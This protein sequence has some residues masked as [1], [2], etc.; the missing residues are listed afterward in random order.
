MLLEAV[1]P[2]I[3]ALNDQ[4]QIDCGA[5]D[6]IL[7]RKQIPVGHIE[8][9]DI[10]D[11]LDRTEKGEQ[12]AKYKAPLENLILTDYL[13]FRFYLRGEKVDTVRIAEISGGRIVALPESFERLKTLL[14]DFAAFQGQTIRSAKKLA[15]MMA[16]KARLMREVFFNAVTG[17]EQS[18]LKDQLKA[19]QTILV[20]DMDARQFADV[21]AQTIAYGLFT[22]RLHDESRDDFSRGEALTLIPKSNPFLRQLFEYVAG[23]QLDE[24]VIWIVDELCKVFRAADLDAILKDFGTATGQKDPILHFYETFLAE[25]DPKL[26]KSRGV[27]YTPEPVVNFIVRAIDDVLKEH[28]GLKDGIADTTK[29]KIRVAA[30]E[31]DQ[32]TKTGRKMFEREVHKVQLLDVAAGTGTFLA[33]AVKQIYGRFGGQEGLW[34][35]YVEEDLL[36]RLHGFEL[37][38]ASY[39]MCHMKLDLLLRETG[40]D[41]SKSRKQ[42]R[43]SVYL[44]N[45]L[46]EEHKDS[47]LPFT[48]WL[49]N[50]ANQAN[51]IKRDMPIMVAFGNPP[52]SGHS[53]NKGEWIE[54]LLEAYKKEPGGKTRLQERNSKWLN[55]DYVKFIRL[56]EHYIEKNGEGVLAYITNHSYLDNPTFRGMRWHLLNTFDEI[57]V[58]DLHGN[59]KKKEITPDGKPDKNVFDIQQGVAIIVAAK[60]SH[61]RH[62]RGASEGRLHSGDPENENRMPAQGGHD[63][64]SGKRLATINY[65]D[66]WGDRQSKYDCLS[67]NGI[68]S[69]EWEILKPASTE[70]FFVPKNHDLLEEFKKG[71]AVNELFPVNSVGIVTARDSL[72]IHESRND[73]I[74][75]IE[76]FSSL[77]P[78]DARKEFDLGKDV[79]DWK[80]QW[81]QDDLNKTSL[82][83]ENI[84]P[85]LYRPFDMHWTYYT[86]HSR[87]FHCM[88]RGEVMRHLKADDNIG[89]VIGR[90]GQVVGSM[91]WNLAFV[92][93]NI[94]DFN[95]FYRGG[96]LVFPIYRH[97]KHFGETEVKNP[98]LDPKIYSR[99]KEVV[100][101]I[102]PESLFDYIYAVLHSPEY[103]ARYSEFLKSDFPRIPYPKDPETFHALAGHGAALRGLHLMESPVLDKLITTYPIPGDHEVVKP[104]FEKH[105]SPQPSPRGEGEKT[106]PSGE[107]ETQSVSGEGQTGKVFINETQY[108]GG[109]PLAAWNFYIG[110]YQPAQKWL[111]DR[112]G[113]NLTASDIKHWQRIIVALQETGR[114][115]KEINKID[116]LPKA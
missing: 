108:F 3:M 78:E 35:T 44:T 26:R 4:A 45:S 17:E 18:T 5:P 66:L 34:G 92:T 9:K 21:Y 106:S 54:S 37:L 11:N 48:N 19:F 29:I 111:K 103:R 99:I 62:P 63:V 82:N 97:D 24:R 81:A 72:T 86:G 68:S 32:R 93:N 6:F 40:Y 114:I 64:K 94:I 80:V 83:Q 57:Y 70:Y 59:A 109:V 107:V 89:L 96:G 71:M 105:P 8:A 38:M 60:Y 36:P 113:R 101:D 16:H 2:D 27:W 79:R 85:I 77:P 73:L 91:E 49:S 1:I 87:G 7:Y 25:Y 116:F 100:P 84:C 23:S 110:G 43:L 13:E 88:P 42:Q 75:T 50:E 95:V 51:E 67:N 56:G 52:Y 20:N 76:R 61:L 22:A 102:T 46:E 53:A 69:L 55:D 41:V 90:Q 115:M 39:A 74:R 28:F 10:G 15:A 31:A 104:R 65:A 98:N 47:Y 30:Q 14:I 33:E 12:I 112:K 58:I